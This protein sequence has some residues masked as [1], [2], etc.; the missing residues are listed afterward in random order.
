MT[1][2]AIENFVQTTDNTAASTSGAVLGKDDFLKLLVTQMKNQDPL[3]PMDGTEY[4]AQLAQFSSLEALQNIDAEIQQLKTT[5]AAANNS[6]AADYLGKTVTAV[7]DS[8]DLSNGTV[9]NLRYR[10]DNAAAETYV[11]V[12]N[13]AGQYVTSINSGAR[14][15]GE[16]MFTWDGLDNQ[17]VAAP[18]GAYFIEVMAVDGNG[19][20]VATETVFSGQ[21]TEINFRDDTAYILVGDREVTLEDIRKISS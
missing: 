21:A 11:K 5:Q 18:D 16:H 19:N 7:G 9:S 2:S 4:T 15:A 10:L 8:F 20:P 17:G 3:N 13:G 1:I 6:R 14:A 12:Y